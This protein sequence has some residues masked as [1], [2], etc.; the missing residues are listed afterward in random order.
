M[1]QKK[2]FHILDAISVLM[3][4]ILASFIFELKID[5]KQA[6]NWMTI[7]KLISLSVSTFSFY[8][9]M[10]K[11]RELYNEAENDDKN[12]T[13]LMIK[14]NNPIIK[15]YELKYNKEKSKVYILIVISIVSVLLFFLLEPI[16]SI[17]IT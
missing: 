17:V 10:Y 7:I 12:E 3:F 5:F 2:H 6:I 4:A 11:L 15:R 8:F 1:I 13:D 16:V 9:A 14:A